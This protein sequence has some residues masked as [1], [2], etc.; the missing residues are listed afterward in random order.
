MEKDGQAVD[1]DFGTAH[2]FKYF[3]QRHEHILLTKHLYCIVLYLCICIALLEVHT[4]QK[5]F[6]CERPR[7]KRTVLRERIEALGSPVNKVDGVE[8]GSWF[9]GAGPMIAKACV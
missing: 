8:G 6:Q 4:N 5:R 7:E 2:Y 1:A 9:Q 3:I